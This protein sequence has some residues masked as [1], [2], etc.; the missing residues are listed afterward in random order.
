MS[1]QSNHALHWEKSFDSAK[2]KAR[3]NCRYARAFTAMLGAVGVYVVFGRTL[4]MSSQHSG[5]SS[6]AAVASKTPGNRQP[7]ASLR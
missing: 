5:G 6:P 7:E 2:D 3:S 1:S 4:G